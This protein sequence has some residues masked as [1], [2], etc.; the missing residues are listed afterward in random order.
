MQNST[1]PNSR[2]RRGRGLLLVGAPAWTREMAAS[3]ANRDGFR[4]QA[5]YGEVLAQNEPSTRART[6]F[7]Q[8]A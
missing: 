7:S 6:T 1:I 5:A 4:K 3:A 2:G 8:K